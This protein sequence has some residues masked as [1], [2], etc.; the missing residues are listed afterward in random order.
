MDWVGLDR[1]RGEGARTHILQLP[2]SVCQLRE[3]GIIGFLLVDIP[4]LIQ[5]KKN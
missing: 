4:K 3:L 2:P 5:D 1:G